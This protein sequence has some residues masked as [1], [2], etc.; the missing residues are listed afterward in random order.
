MYNNSFGKIKVITG[1]MF[2]GKSEELL[3]EINILSIVGIETLIIKPKIDNRFSENKIISRNG[4]QV[5]SIVVS[6]TKELKELFNSKYKT[7]IIDE[8]QF[9]DE[10]LYFFVN[11]LA[12]KGVHVIVSGLDMDFQMKPFS[13]MANISA[14]ADNILK[15]KAVCMLCKQE[16]NASFRKNMSKETL[17]LG[18]VDEYEARCRKC[19]QK[20]EIEKENGI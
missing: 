18:D 14:I 11:E 4:R 10:E 5:E 3:R 12:N 9:F 6:N 13:V 17:Q 7:I 19:H 15:L 16:A 2:S 20:G 1:P 8:A